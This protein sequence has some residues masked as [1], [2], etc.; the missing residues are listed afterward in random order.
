MNLTVSEL[1]KIASKADWRPRL[2][3]LHFL[4]WSVRHE[5]RRDPSNGLSTQDELEG[6][7]LRVEEEIAV[8][9]A[10]NVLTDEER[11]IVFSLYFANKSVSWLAKQKNTSVGKL[12]KSLAGALNKM[13]A[14]LDQPPVREVVGGV[15]PWHHEVKIPLAGKCSDVVH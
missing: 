2:K 9:E 15:L 3:G 14:L 4:N 10:I 11:E 5:I 7:Q 6:Y 12:Q 8:Q 13:K 1:E